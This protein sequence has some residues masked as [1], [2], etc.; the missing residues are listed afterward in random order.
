MSNT[1]TSIAGNARNGQSTYTSTWITD[2]YEYA[3]LI[4][5]D[6]HPIVCQRTRNP[7]GSWVTHDVFDTI[8]GLI[9]VTDSHMGISIG[10][11]QFGIIHVTGNTHDTK[12][13]HIQSTS[14]HDITDWEDAPLIERQARH[15]TNLVEN[16]VVENNLDGWV[17]AFP[18]VFTMDRVSHSY[19]W[20]SSHGNDTDCMAVRLTRTAI[21]P[22]PYIGI[23]GALS[24]T[25]NGFPA[26]AGQ[27]YN[28][29]LS[30]RANMGSPSAVNHQLR[31]IFRDASDAVISYVDSAVQSAPD[32]TKWYRCFV[33]EA[34]APANTTNIQIGYST[35]L[36]SGNA[37]TGDELWV[38]GLMLYEGDAAGD[39]V[40]RDGSFNGG[41]DA[42]GWVWNG[43]PYASTSTGPIRSDG[44]AGINTSTYNRTQAFSDG[45]L[46]LSF[47]QHTYV[48]D[49]VGRAWSVW[50]MGD[51]GF[52]PLTNQDG[53][54]MRTTMKTVLQG[55]DYPIFST[56]N[57]NNDA[58]IA[59]RSYAY[60]IWIDKRDTLHMF[61]W[62]RVQT[63][64]A[65]GSLLYV[66]SHDQGTT[67]ENVQG[68]PVTMPLTYPDALTDA[69][70][71]VDGTTPIPCATLGGISESNGNPMVIVGESL[72]G[73]QRLVY[74]DGSA[75]VNES[76]ASYSF[77]DLP[78][79]QYIR[80]DVWLFGV[81]TV[82]GK[83]S[84]SLWGVNHTQGT[85]EIVRLGAA[86]VGTPDGVY[87]FESGATY[88]G[89]PVHAGGLDTRG[90]YIFKR[91]V[92]D[93]NTPVIRQ[94][95]G[96]PRGT[97]T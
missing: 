90:N 74:W 43:T 48:N 26:T 67:W 16:G 64:I 50:K 3:I 35:Q 40:Y 21:A 77:L 12:I 56:G 47:A 17:S 97:I 30:F 2:D 82:G 29:S 20:G 49:P 91:L 75:W 72:G 31:V 60:G 76:I 23:G 70:V 94:F 92:P 86:T 37:A 38:D 25:G 41:E 34:I 57:P 45:T 28:A 68:D 63:D 66:R 7:I 36:A 15:I 61:C 33:E 65:Y 4:R 95:G 46:V 52:E 14:P 88:E 18:T 73:G 1:W 96:G 22:S 78:S 83:G 8:I 27:S 44:Y 13:R 39:I 11:D 32:P 58:D 84:R 5:H 69:L 53:C 85:G 10:V 93:D 80:G 87:S 81:K 59:D 9:E 6:W 42:T 54:V 24:I 89:A 51:N 62:F 79:V 71:S 55:S 19:G